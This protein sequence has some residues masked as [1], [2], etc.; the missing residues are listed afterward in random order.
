MELDSALAPHLS[1]ALALGATLAQLKSVARQF[2]ENYADLYEL[3][4]R[5]LGRPP[6]T[7]RT[8]VS[9]EW[10]EVERLCQF[11]QKGNSDELYAHVQ[12]KTQ[13]MRRLAGAE[14]GSINYFRVL[15][16]VL[17]LKSRRGRQPDWKVDRV[18]G[19]NACAALKRTLGELENSLTKELEQARHS[20]F[21]PILEGLRQFALEYAKRRKSEGRAEFHDLLAWAREVLRDN[22]EVRDYFRRRFTHLLID[23][24]QDTDPIQTGIAMYLAESVPE[25]TPDRLRTKKWEQITPEEG[26]L[27]VVG[28]PKQSIYRFRRADVE[29]MRHFQ[30]RMEQTG[31]R[32]LSLVQNFRS[33]NGIIAWVNQL[34]RD[35][36]EDDRSENAGESYVQARYEN[37]SASRNGAP[38]TPHPQVWALGDEVTAGGIDSVRRQEAADIATL[39]RQMLAQKWQTKD[40]EASPQGGPEAHR[41]VK[42]SDICI[43][44]PSR[45]GIRELERGLEARYIPYRLEG[46]SLIFETQEVRDLM[47]CLKAID[48]PSNQIAIVAAL[49]SPAFGCS[50]IDL[51]KH[52]E[53]GGGFSYT[54][55][56]ASDGP[57]AEAL[58]T[59]HRFNRERDRS[60]VGYLID[61]FIREQG[62][63]Q[64]AVG[65]PLMREQWRR[66]RFLVERARQFSASGA[67]SLRAFLEWMEE[68]ITEGARVTEAPV[69]ES[70]EEA[71][72]VMTVH[73]AKGLEFPV[74]I[75]TGVNYPPRD[76]STPV[77][78]DRKQRQV[79]AGIGSERERFRTNGYEEL[80]SREKLLSEAERVRLM[81]VA[82]T[83]ARDHLVISLRRTSGGGEK[84][85]AG[86]ISGYL[87]KSPELWQ[88]VVL[89][90]LP[91][92]S[93]A[94]LS[95]N[96][97]GTSS[98]GNAS[99][100]DTVAERDQWLTERAALFGGLCRPASIAA[101][102]LGS[103]RGRT[104]GPQ[105][106]AEGGALVASS[107]GA[108]GTAEGRAVSSV[109]QT[110][111]LATGDGIASLARSQ[112]VAHGA[113]DREAEVA[114]LSRRAADSDIV[115][116][117]VSSGRFWRA[118]Q[119][120]LPI[121]DGSLQGAI[122]LL[123]EEVDGLVAVF[124]ES[125]FATTANS[126]QEAPRSRMQAGAC[127]LALERL[128]GK[129]VKEVVFL[130]LQ[131]T[132]QET[133]QD[134]AAAM[135]DAQ[136]E[137]EALLSRAET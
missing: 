135:R 102:S 35:W 127:A 61:H 137:A 79:E 36:M 71:V 2:H 33:Q 52:R 84:T 95:D 5:D 54:Q 119:V 9:E 50:D 41:A 17:P 90:D 57:V 111:D 116:R 65:H 80:L 129:P 44:M 75:L 20:A 82:A 6:T 112:A 40:E 49:R 29:Q 118:V 14:P 131:P 4:F 59:L 98:K 42:Y 38:N 128:T 77:V 70:D 30:S 117:A 45:A 99:T 134:L 97:D 105:L 60:S 66:Y 92:E 25:G 18:T 87:S 1:V 39:L 10:D 101:N 94:Q 122:D 132:R 31:G 85:L 19:D 114:Q 133:L 113:P 81:Y 56:R 120:A 8:R 123:F 96:P 16:R 78:F 67:K 86:I 7:A 34:F 76:R 58:A 43:L 48:D 28:D 104:Q 88:P 121:G 22:L 74:V 15:G 106:W 115:R 126:R 136:E 62:L 93:D 21:V 69:P 27:F 3:E 124:Y 11:S 32:K 24:A 13:E 83:R 47:N 46:A 55:G 23:E 91:I 103:R 108:A 100:G 64:V 51:F 26:K 73:A 37:M 12:S 110:V 68:Q 89:E 53:Q 130:Y 107:Q 72:R 109:L 63:M 125:D